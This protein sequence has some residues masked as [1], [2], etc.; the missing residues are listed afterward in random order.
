MANSLAFPLSQAQQVVNCF[1]ISNFVLWQTAAFRYYFNIRPLWIAFKLVILSYGKQ[2]A[3]NVSGRQ[4]VV[5]CFQISNFVL[6]QTAPNRVRI[7]RR[8][9]WIAFKLVILSYGKQHQAQ[10]LYIGLVVN[11]FQISNFVLWQTAWRFLWARHSKLWIAFKLV[12][13]SYG[14]QPLSDIISTFD[15][16]ELLSN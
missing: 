9:L 16:C 4:R 15:R 10:T 1:Q 8:V 11:C 5:N 14:K 7:S 3:N 12:I 13:L 2:L 6:W